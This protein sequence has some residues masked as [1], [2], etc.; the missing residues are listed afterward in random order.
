MTGLVDQRVTIEARSSFAKWEESGSNESRFDEETEVELVAGIYCKRIRRHLEIIPIIVKL[1][2]EIDTSWEVSSKKVAGLEGEG[3][4]N[5][6]P[7]QEWFWSEEWQAAEREAE[8]DLAAGRYEVFENDED[9]LA[10]LE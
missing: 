7:G 10:S 3:K 4:P 8:A 1:T 2:D 9:F 5:V 6:K